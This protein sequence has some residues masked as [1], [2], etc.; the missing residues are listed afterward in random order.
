[1]LLRL[2]RINFEI[3]A[4]YPCAF[5]ILETGSV[6]LGSMDHFGY[7]VL[8]ILTSHDI[9]HCCTFPATNFIYSKIINAKHSISGVNVRFRNTIPR[10]K[11]YHV[12]M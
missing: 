9:D 12:Y 1:M 2:V 4:R 3:M 7:L 8:S 5:E 11:M 6:I 10:N